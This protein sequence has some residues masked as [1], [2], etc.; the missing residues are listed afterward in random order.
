MRS[1]LRRGTLPAADAGADRARGRRVPR[2]RVRRRG[3]RARRPQPSGSSL[4]EIDLARRFTSRDEREAGAAALPRD[5]CSRTAA[6]VPVH[7]HEEAREQGWT[8]EQILEALGACGAR[9]LLVPRDAC[10]RDPARGHLARGQAAQEGRLATMPGRRRH[11]QARRRNRHLPSPR[12]SRR[13]GPQNRGAARLVARRLSVLPRGGGAARQALDRRDRP[14]AAAAARCAS[15]RSRRRSRRSRTA[16][17]RCGCKELEACGIVAA[18]RS[19]DG[20]GA[21]RVRADAQG[22]GARADGPALRPLGARVAQ[23]RGPLK[24]ACAR[25]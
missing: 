2:L 14:R 7:L 10:R 4:D 11:S 21:G 19:D 22:P 24:R 20:P 17:C 18:P 6:Q 3:P 16:C 15:P 1:E 13:R 23:G 8:D 12:R 25:S 5:R 9:R